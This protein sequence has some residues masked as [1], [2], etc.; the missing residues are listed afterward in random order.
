MFV[1]INVSSVGFMKYFHG[2]EVA[3]PLNEEAEV[4]VRRYCLVQVFLKI[5]QIS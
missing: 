2:S 1:M 4:A 3:G 5:S